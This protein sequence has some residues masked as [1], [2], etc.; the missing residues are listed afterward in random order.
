MLYYIGIYIQTE[1][2]YQA[3]PETEFNLKNI[4]SISRIDA[5]E[6]ES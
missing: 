5:I 4:T 6:K 3:E 1:S 2:V